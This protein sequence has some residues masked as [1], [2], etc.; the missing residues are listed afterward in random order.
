MLERLVNY[1]FKATNNEAEYEAMI[2]DLSLAKKMGVQRLTVCSDSQLLINQMQGHYQ[3]YGN[4]M[5]PYLD[6][7]KKLTASFQ[8][9]VAR[10][11][12]KGENNHADVLANVGSATKTSTPKVILVVY[13]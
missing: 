12:P 7:V 1:G 4:K 6:I 2:T 13:L 9:Y 3:V 11:V 8:E 5:T 10:Q